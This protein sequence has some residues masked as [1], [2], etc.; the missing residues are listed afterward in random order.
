MAEK[1]PNTAR[2]VA[3]GQLQKLSTEQKNYVADGFSARS[4]AE[5]I[6]STDS[7]LNVLMSYEEV[8]GV[9]TRHSW[10]STMVCDLAA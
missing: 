6:K 10:R 7:E 8:T 2:G 3:L 5:E 1:E 9:I 4:R